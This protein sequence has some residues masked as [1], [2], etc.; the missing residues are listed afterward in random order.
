MVPIVAN[1]LSDIY[2][3]L[4]PKIICQINETKTMANNGGLHNEAYA[5]SRA[6]VWKLLH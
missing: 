6:N 4:I 2:K 1:F 5:M 3:L